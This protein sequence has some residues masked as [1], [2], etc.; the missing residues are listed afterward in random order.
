MNTT[1]PYGLRQRR[2][3]RNYRFPHGEALAATVADSMKVLALIQAAAAWKLYGLTRL[4]Q[5][6][7][8][9]AGATGPHK[10]ITSGQ[11]GW[12]LARS[13]SS[14][15]PAGLGPERIVPSGLTSLNYAVPMTAAIPGARGTAAFLEGEG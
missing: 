10:R 15:R 3:M 4:R 1:L 11:P 5:A 8:P 7:L 12:R 6:T 2:D 9:S 14:R 13:T